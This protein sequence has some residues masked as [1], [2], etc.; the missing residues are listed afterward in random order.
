VGQ[1]CPIKPKGLSRRHGKHP[2]ISALYVEFPFER[3]DNQ[4][5]AAFLFRNAER[6]VFG[7]Q[8]SVGQLI[9]NDDLRRMAARVVIDREFRNSL[10]SNNPALPKLWKKH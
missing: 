10:V 6:T 4:W 2:W 3:E 7:I 1:W 8:E 5:Y 9:H